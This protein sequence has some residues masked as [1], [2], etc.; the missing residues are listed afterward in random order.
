MADRNLVLMGEIISRVQ[1]SLYTQIDEE[2]KGFAALQRGKAL[3]RFTWMGHYLLSV[4]GTG[5][6]PSPSVHCDQCCRKN[7]RDGSLTCHHQ[8]LGAALV[9]PRLKQV[10]PLPPEPI[11]QADGSKKNDCERNAAKWLLPRIRR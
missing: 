2:P 11:M 1:C 6:F 4:D 9:H 3:E 10:I 5:Y 7:H 8:M